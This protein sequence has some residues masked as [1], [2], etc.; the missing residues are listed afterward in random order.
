MNRIASVAVK[1]QRSGRPIRQAIWKEIT[2]WV[3]AFC[4]MLYLS[5]AHA[6]SGAGSIQGTV[7]DSTGAIM[8]GALIH[9]INQVTQVTAD[10]KSNS[11]GF[12]QVPDLFAGSYKV[13]IIAPGMKTYVQVI[14]LLANQTAAINAVMTPGSV[15]SQVTVIGNPIQLTDPTSGTLSSTLD[16]QRISE[17]PMNTRELLSLAYQSEP[18]FDAPGSAGMRANGLMPEALEYVAD[19]VPLTNRNFGGEDNSQQATLPD[20]DSV[21]EVTFSLTDAPAQ[22]ATPGTAVITTKSGTNELH[23]S[24]FETAVNSYWG[25]AKVRQDLSSFVAPP[26]VRNE[27]GASAGGPIYFPHLYHGKDKSFWF[28]AYERYSL[29]SVADESVNVPTLAERQGDFSGL[30]NSAGQLA[31]LYDP[32]TT[33]PNAACPVPFSTTGAT[34][35]NNYCR[36]PFPNNQIPLGRMSPFAKLLY[37]ITPSPSNSND[38]LVKANLTANDDTYVV[39]PTITLRLDQNFSEN[40]KAYLRYTQ[41]NQYNRA[42]RNYPN[43]SPAT[44]AANGFP[45]GA[46]GYQVIPISNYGAALGY[47]HIF[48]P[49][50]FSETIVSQQWFMQYVGGGGDP[51][52]NYNQMFGLPDNFGES[53]FPVI[54][55]LTMDYGGTMYQ[56]QENQIISQVDENLTKTVGKHQMQFGGRVRH[57]RLYYLNSRNADTASFSAGQATGLEEPST[58]A[59]YTAYP[60]TGYG[61]ADGFLGGASEY[62]VQLEPPPS[63]FGDTE[64]DGYFQDNWHATRNFTVNIG[65]RYEAHPAKQTKDGVMNSFDLK[66]HAIVLGAPISQLISQGWTTQAI[67]SNMEN[68]GVKFEDARTAGYPDALYEN[69]NLEV[70]PRIGLAWQPYGDQVGT[71]FRGGYGRYIYPIPT[72]NSNPGPSGLPFAYGYTQNYASASQSPDS[73]PNYWLRNPLTVIAG[74]NSSDVVD[75]TTTTAIVPGFGDTYFDP[76]YKPDLVTEV[77]AT[78]EQPLKWNSVVRFSYV[79]THG[80]NLDHAYYPND[81]LPTFVWE[82][83]TGTTPPNGGPSTIGTNQ[84]AATALNPYDNTV[85]GNFNWDEKS[86]WSNDDALQVNF[87]RFYHRGFGYQIYWVWSKSFR[88]GGNS[89]RDGQIY[90]PQDYLGYL[91]IT[92]TYS[93][94]YPITTPKVPPLNPAGTSAYNDW[95][96]LDRWEQWQRDGD[97]PPQHVGFNYI[98]DL[99]FGRGKKILGSSNRFLNQIVGGYQ[100]AGDGFI[101]SQIFAVA[102][103]NWGPEHPIQIYKHN[104]PITDCRSGQCYKEYQWFNGYIAPTANA[105]LGCTSKCVYGLPS[106]YQPYEE[107]ID[108]VPGTPNYNTNNVTVNLSNGTQVTQSFGSGAQGTN[109]YAKTYIT[110]PINWGADI[111]LYKVF[112]IT[113]AMNLRFNMD[114]FNFLNHQGWNNPNSTDGTQDYIAGGASGAS[115]YN[116]GRQVQFTLRFTF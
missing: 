74:Q 41:N 11:A 94:P 27:F 81:A 32:A 61:D 115:S 36:T 75:T 22:Y 2:L 101:R 78:V 64:Y 85:Y 91:P 17:I 103:S 25:V 92:A 53:G 97:V 39:V 30:I 79:H 69:A 88:L 7:T 40:N 76:D 86:G 71:V 29:A 18:G 77:N 42:L 90:A 34:V 70:S 98:F 83:H 95:H 4:L 48:S 96:A 21:K 109:P 105:N 63:W 108:T 112:P 5:V 50:F 54:S 37:A 60:Y 47:D 110:G 12:Y 51:N 43:D 35:N 19:G 23:G 73:L 20:P 52:L 38:P 14:Q 8:P 80:T 16:E 106:N 55:G 45:A 56:Y 28:F 102:D 72:R 66:N 82:M 67:I 68:I 6:Q 100:I 10:T 13:T 59:S 89:T 113:E 15:T 111:S 44:I 31:Q 65:L 104:M 9:V 93:S 87:Q 3:P 116:T 58:G 26:Y 84:Y 107:P 24:L 1:N 49:T 99:P 46:S 62:Q 114:V 57:E 33:T